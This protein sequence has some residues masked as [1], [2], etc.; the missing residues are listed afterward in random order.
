MTVLYHTGLLPSGP[1]RRNHF[2]RLCPTADCG[3]PTVVGEVDVRH[4]THR[5]ADSVSDVSKF[6]RLAVAACDGKER[7]VERVGE[8][9]LVCTASPSQCS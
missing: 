4:A 8:A 5:D 9:D 7:P 6:P 1:Q 2:A 3:A